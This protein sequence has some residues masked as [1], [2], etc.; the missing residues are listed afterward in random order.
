M[1]INTMSALIVSPKYDTHNPR[2]YG[3]R[4]AQKINAKRVTV[5]VKSLAK[6]SNRV[7]VIKKLEG[8]QAT[9]KNIARWLNTQ[10]MK[11]PGVA[12]F[13]FGG[14]GCK[15]SSSKWPVL[16]L[17]N[18]SVSSNSVMHSLESIPGAL[19]VAHLDA[20]NCKKIP[21]M[22]KSFIKQAR[23][24]LAIGTCL[25][26][27]MKNSKKTASRAERE[28]Q[29]AKALLNDAHGH[30]RIAAASP[31]QVSVGTAKL[32]GVNTILLH[33]ALSSVCQKGTK[34][35]WK[36]VGKTMKKNMR[37]C[38]QTPMVSVHVKKKH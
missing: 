6:A 22:T 12:I 24:S 19:T 16:K 20:C 8:K 25:T 36:K 29:G 15:D 7:P 38:S 21:H 9:K 11:P 5:A 27:K 33:A 10:K 14:H 31:D 1:S 37:G 34:A 3:M 13:D 30:V 18:E 17:S 32:G 4:K 28:K 2:N 23:K 35:T 26:K